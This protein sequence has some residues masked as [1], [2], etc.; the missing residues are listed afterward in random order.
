MPL[1]AAC[2]GKVSAPTA[3]DFFTGLSRVPSSAETTL[4]DQHTFGSID[5]MAVLDPDV[6]VVSDATAGRVKLFAGGHEVASF[7]R[8]GPGPDDFT[9]V[10]AVAAVRA[11]T[12]VV[13]D[14]NRGR[15]VT[16][17]RATDSV[18]RVGPVDLPFAVSGVCALDSRLFVLGRYDSTLVHETTT[19]GG[20]VRSFGALKGGTPF[21][22]GL[23]AAAEIGCSSEAGAV[24]VASRVPGELLLFSPDGTLMRRDSIPSFRRSGY[25]GRRTASPADTSASRSWN[26]VEGLQWF[27]QDLLVQLGRYPKTGAT[28]LE[29]RWL[30]ASGEWKAGLP[31]WPKILA[32]SGDGRVYTLSR[33]PYPVVKVY[34]VKQ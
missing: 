23:N 34:W 5:G 19:H 11:D 12:F 17:R 8:V 20:L 24:A 21:E 25:V 31:A 16:F 3:K 7:G 4:G 10:G 14:P 2:G 29:S 26:V 33:D 6:E 9:T 30:T 22:V 1:V 13:L 28:R 18:E 32:H 15:L 27:G